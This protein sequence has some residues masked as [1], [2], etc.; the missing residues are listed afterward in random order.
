MDTHPELDSEQRYLD[1]AYRCL[2]EM[3]DHATRTL[4]AA[5]RAAREEATPDADIVLWHL[6]RRLATLAETPAALTFG[7]LDDEAGDR[8]YIGRRHVEDRSRPPPGRLPPVRAPRGARA[9]AHAR[10]RA[11]PHLPA[12]HRPGPAVAGR[13]RGRAGDDRQPGR[14]AVAGAGRRRARRRAAEG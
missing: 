2:D 5:E 12:L 6:E 9:P 8:F 11:Q 3:R 13:D 4:T 1:H 7:R 10:H 14:G